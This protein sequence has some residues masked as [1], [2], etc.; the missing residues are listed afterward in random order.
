[1]DARYAASAQPPADAAPLAALDALSG[2]GRQRAAARRRCPPCCPRRLG[3]CSSRSRTLPTLPSTSCLLLAARGQQPL[4]DAAHPALHACLLLEAGASGFLTLA[5]LWP[6]ALQELGALPELPL[7]VAVL[8]SL[9]PPATSAQPPADAAL[10][11]SLDALAGAGACALEVALPA[12]CARLAAPRP[13]RLAMPTPQLLPLFA[14][15]AQQPLTDVAHPALHVLS[16]AGCTRAAA[17]HRRCPPCPPRLSAAGICIGASPTSSLRA[18][19]RPLPLPPGHAADS[20]IAAT[21]RHPGMQ[22]A[23]SNCPPT[24]PSLPSTP[25]LLLE[26]GA[27]GFLT[28]AVLWPPALQEL[29][30]LPELPLRVAVLLSLVPPV[31]GPPAA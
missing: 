30:A 28:L 25:C 2:A 11:A 13:S 12:R 26:A 31:C 15:G 22:P 27:S 3:W 7:R 29:G 10:L 21:R 19:N 23:R 14:A 9:V 1:M 6:P 24:L 18:A 16:A 17:A 4:T 20:S 8:L 5:V